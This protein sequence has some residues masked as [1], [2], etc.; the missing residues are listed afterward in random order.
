M[1]KSDHEG[2]SWYMMSFG[3]NLGWGR[4]SFVLNVLRK[5]LPEAALNQKKTTHVGLRQ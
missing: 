1:R 3:T 2:I 5:D 4:I